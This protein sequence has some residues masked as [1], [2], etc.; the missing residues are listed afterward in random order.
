M[1]DGCA[2]VREVAVALRTQIMHALATMEPQ[3]T[4]GVLVAQIR[5]FIRMRTGVAPCSTT[6][7]KNLGVLKRGGFVT[8]LRQRRYR[9][10]QRTGLPYDSA[11]DEAR[12]IA[13]PFSTST[14][15]RICKLAALA[16]LPRTHFVRRL[17]EAALDSLEPVLDAAEIGTPAPPEPKAVEAD[18]YPD[19]DDG[20]DCQF[21][22]SQFG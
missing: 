22:D 17:V 1:S 18:Q 3:H 5:E 21:E 2:T 19:D 4:R 11:H 15:A 6:L 14:H 8:N 13:V 20:E 12:P 7:G 10:W 9:Y 16:G